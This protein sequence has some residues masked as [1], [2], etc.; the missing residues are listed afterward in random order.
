VHATEWILRRLGRKRDA[1]LQHQRDTEDRT[2][3][4]DSA[5]VFLDGTFDV[6]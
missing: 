2:A 3:G 5:A 1:R 6:T 4:G